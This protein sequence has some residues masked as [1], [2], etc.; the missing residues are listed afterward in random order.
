MKRDP[1]GKGAI[2][3]SSRNLANVL[4]ALAVVG[5]VVGVAWIKTEKTQSASE[6]G[7]RHPAA[8]TRPIGDK[9]LPGAGLETSVPASTV[10]PPADRSE[11]LPR[12]VDL[13]SDSCIPCKKLAPILKELRK[14]LEGRVIVEFIDV[15]KN[16]AAG[17]PYG[18]RAIPTQIL[19]DRDGREVWRHEGFISKESLVAKLAEIGVR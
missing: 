17:K 9:V 13:G 18:I 16:P 2:A 19:Y 8:A 11:K 10:A 3:V 1:S 14:E 12:L 5:V 7:G 4:V 15:W 6:G